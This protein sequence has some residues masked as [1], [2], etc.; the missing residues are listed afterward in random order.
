MDNTT[1]NQKNTRGDVS[2]PADLTNRL[3]PYPVGKRATLL[4]RLY[5]IHRC[6][7]L[8]FWA[9]GIG[10]WEY[11]SFPEW[12][13]EQILILLS[14]ELWISRGKMSHNQSRKHAA[15]PNLRW[16]IMEHLNGTFSLLYLLYFRHLTISTYY[17]SDNV[18]NKMIMYLKISKYMFAIILDC[19]LR[20]RLYRLVDTIQQMNTLK[21]EL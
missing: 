8:M 9:R 14:R 15:S 13:A 16:S 12:L 20:D 6:E 17:V 2:T 1:T 21:Q 3:L 10:E 7:S 4:A 18:V 19:N 5:Q 11:C